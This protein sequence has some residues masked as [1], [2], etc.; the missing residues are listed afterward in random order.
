MSLKALRPLVWVHIPK[1]GTSFLNTLLFTVCPEWPPDWK[2][3]P[4]AV[5]RKSIPSLFAEYSLEEFCDGGFAADYPSPARGG[6][7][8][9]GDELYA[10]HRGR[11]M[12][13]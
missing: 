11:L 4:A 8:G 9:V 13:M 5:R 2:M 7:I 12:G 3:R 10:R 1:S 6:Q